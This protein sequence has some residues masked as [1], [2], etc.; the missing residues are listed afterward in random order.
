MLKPYA[1][2]FDIWADWEKKRSI[3]QKTTMFYELSFFFN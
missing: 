1:L 3:K 2:I